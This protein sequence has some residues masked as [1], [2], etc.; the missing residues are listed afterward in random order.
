MDLR[1]IAKSLTVLSPLMENHEKIETSELV[2]NFP[3]GVHVN[4]CDIVETSEARYSVVLFN[5]DAGK[6]YN[7][8]LVLTKIVD[9]WL[10]VGTLEEIN[11][12]LSKKPVKMRFSEGKTKSGGKNVTI[13]DVL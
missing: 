1:G 6:Y 8:G 10:Q 4:A 9:A 3:D 2:K 12:E 11:N 7:G 13:I 5:E